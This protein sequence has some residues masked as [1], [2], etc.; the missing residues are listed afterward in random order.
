MNSLNAS[1]LKKLFS[2]T[3]YLLIGFITFGCVIIIHELGR[4][5]AC[6]FLG[7]SAPYFFIGFGP[8]IAKLIIGNTTF[9][10]GIVP[11]G[12]L[13]SIDMADLTLQSYLIQMTVFSS[14]II[15]N[16]LV[17]FL[18]Y[19]CLGKS[20]QEYQTII[21]EFTPQKTLPKA[22]SI[23]QKVM[24]PMD[25]IELITTSIHDG[26]SSFLP[27]FALLNILIAIISM[28]PLPLL[29]G[30]QLIRITIA[31]FIDASP[32]SDH[33]VTLTSIVIFVALIF[34]AKCNDISKRSHK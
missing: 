22:Y 12:G 30:W 33:Y 25:I 11:I 31:Q 5:F 24:A 29:D 7:V 13:A 2:Q 14:G 26:L 32:A 23:A 15:I 18:I 10:I 16:F 28:L 8:A 9:A 34:T 27:T 19:R 3:W 1:Y 4:L 6:K 17:A 21:G 20:I